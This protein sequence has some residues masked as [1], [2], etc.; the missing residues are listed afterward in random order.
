MGKTPY[1]L[2]YELLMMAQSILSEQNSNSRFKI[3]SNWNMK[4]EEARAIAE[5]TDTTLIFP[6]FPEIPVVTEQDIIE[7]AKKL[8]EFVSNGDKNND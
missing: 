1:E 2:R 3:E 4:C 8:N 7:T 6:D 5:R